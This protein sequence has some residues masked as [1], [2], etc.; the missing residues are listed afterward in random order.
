ML[1]DIDI[2]LGLQILLTFFVNNVSLYNVG[3]SAPTLFQLTPHL[4]LSVTWWWIL[5]NS[6]PARVSTYRKA[7]E[8]GQCASEAGPVYLDRWGR[9]DGK[10]YESKTKLWSLFIHRCRATLPK[11]K[12]GQLHN[13]SLVDWIV[14]KDL[15]WKHWHQPRW[16]RPYQVLLTPPTAVRIAERD[17]WIHGLKV[18]NPDDDQIWGDGANHTFHTGSAAALFNRTDWCRKCDG[19]VEW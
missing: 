3:R 6:L 15:R 2:H 10:V 19:R 11:P 1:I 9:P 12:G 4:S 18:D 13:I 14:V 16:R 5:S 17:N 8:D 7:D